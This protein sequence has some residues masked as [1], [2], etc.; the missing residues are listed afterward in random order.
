M[1]VQDPI[2]SHKK[3]KGST[4]L[5][6]FSG[7]CERGRSIIAL[8]RGRACCFN[9]LT[10][11]LSFRAKAHPSFQKPLLPW[12]RSACPLAGRRRGKDL[13]GSLVAAEE[14]AAR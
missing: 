12:A 10:S 6:A 1:K 11:V 14:E 3:G 4:R 8:S 7:N 9:T 13:I 2:S 5:A